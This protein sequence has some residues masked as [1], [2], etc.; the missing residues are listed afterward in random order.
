M[1]RVMLTFVMTIA[2]FWVSAQ[3]YNV[4]NYGAKGDGEQLDHTAIN[5]AIAD[6]AAHGGGTVNIP[7]GKYLSGS[8]HLLSNITLNLEA[9]ATIVGAPASMKAY[10]APESFSEKQYQDGG[11]TFFHNSLIWGE[12]LKNVSITGR[13]MIDGGGLTRKDNERAGVVSGGSIGTGDKAIALKNCRNVLIRDI[14]IYHGGHFGIIVT[15]CDLVTLD[16][17]LVDTNRDGIDIDCS[18]HVTVSN[19][20]VNTPN[21]DAIVLKSS[22]ALNKSVATENVLITNCTVTG[23]DEGSLIDGSYSPHKVNWVCGRIKLGT[24]SNGGYNNIT[25]SNCTCLYSNGIALEEVDQGKMDNI[26]ITNISMSHTHY[27]PIYITTGK[28]N[29][30]PESIN[31]TSYGGNIQISNITVDDADPYSGIQITGLP[32]KPL[33]NIRLSNIQVNYQGGGT[34]ELGRKDYPELAKGYPEP[35]QIGPCPAYGLFV[36][37]V[38][39][40]DLRDITFK[41]GTADL[42]PVMIM[43][44][45]Q[46]VLIDNLKAPEVTGILPYRMTDV[47]DIVWTNTPM[48]KGYQQ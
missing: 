26:V 11:H 42:R 23:F 45:A 36:R 28:R 16:N 8:I 44:D 6:C 38:K 3:A 29:R 24:E 19:C 35:M 40:L 5:K 30:G 34:A 2:V 18:K 1:K 31:D 41:T 48:L 46:D 17:L 4:K 22:F 27:Y 32:E 13:G 25:I 21:D 20:K 43:Q 15:G 10:D 33:E 39:G 9:G 12:N 7:A 47:K 37:H 14:T